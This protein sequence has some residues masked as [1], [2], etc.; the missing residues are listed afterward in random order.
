MTNAYP[1]KPTVPY[2]RTTVA[3]ADVISYLQAAPQPVEVKRT[4]YIMW[5]IESANGQSGICNNYVGCQADG[6]R[7]DAKFDASIVGV[8]DMA[9]NGTGRARLFVAFD[10]WQSCMD[11]LLDRVEHRGIYIGGVAI[12]ISNMMVATETDL[13]TAYVREWASGRHDAQP[14]TQQLAGWHSMYGQA[15]AYFRHGVEPAP[16]NVSTDNTNPDN[17]ADT[18]NAAQLIQKDSDMTAVDF[19][20]AANALLALASAVVTAAIPILVPAILRRLRL[21]NNADLVAKVQAVAAAGAGMAYEYAVTHQGS[22]T[23]VPFKDAAVATGVQ[24]VM[25]S[26]P[27]ALKEMGITPDHVSAMVTARL[28]TL[29][30]SD[31][32]ASA[33]PESHASPALPTPVAAKP[34]ATS[35]ATT[36]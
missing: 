1:E 3:M 22:I 25:S 18:L 7:W 27:D 8:V 6:R 23:N 31:P 19:S 13:C 12:P 20:V 29:L 24:H 33:T 11:F 30:A 10:H 9:E 34:P 21:A 16:A 36:A 15:C 32:T 4:A 14:T 17:S 28:G 2:V 26:V 35:P 5:R